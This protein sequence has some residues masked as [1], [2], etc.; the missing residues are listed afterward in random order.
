MSTPSSA[1]V[2]SSLPTSSPSAQ[3]VDARGVLAFLDAVEAHPLIDPHSVVLV[4]HG[5]VVARGWWAPYAP[6]QPHL[7]YSL[8]KSF[9]ATALGMAVADGVLS[10]D[11]RL[12]DVLPGLADAATS[13]R[14]RSLTLRHLVGMGS[15]HLSETWD[16]AQAADPDEPLRGFLG[17]EPEREPGTVFAYNQPCTYAVGAA[18]QHARGET[19]LDHLHSR[20]FEP[21][22]VTGTECFGWQQHPAGRD[23]GFTG[24]HAT[25]DAVAALGVLLLQRGRWGG[26]QLL[27][28]AWVDEASRAHLPTPHQPEV[29]WRQGYGFQLWRQRHGYRGDGAFGQFMLVLPEHDAVVAITSDT[30]DMQA[31]LDAVWTHLLPALDDDERARSASSADADDE[32]AQRLVALA[33]PPADGAA[34]PSDELAWDGLL[35]TPS[36]LLQPGDAALS[37]VRVERRAS[38]WW[39]VVQESAVPEGWRFEVPVAAGEWRLHDAPV[40]EDLGRTGG[41]VVPLAVSGGWV[42]A[43][44]GTESLQVEVRFLQT[45]HR[46][47]ISGEAASASL[48]ARWVTPPLRAGSLAELRSPALARPSTP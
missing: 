23:L 45:P 20:V 40:P 4:R 32:L 44:G 46:L 15:G 21:L 6:E 3:G 36:A 11:D 14:A 30:P 27:P 18:V 22:G 47:V 5:H 16:R 10:L 41:G 31:V 43:V 35:L 39:L 7:L 48:R 8:S 12:V 38:G 1:V 34:E 25:T 33:L 17:I 9:T 24:L 19:L 26:E 42:R 29:D 37:D 28:A 2:P 13:E